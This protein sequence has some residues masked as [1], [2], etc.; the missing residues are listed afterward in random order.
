MESLLNKQKSLQLLFICKK[1]SITELENFIQ[2]IDK[3]YFYCLFLNQLKLRNLEFT[4][5]FNNFGEIKNK[6]PPILITTSPEC[7]DSCNCIKLSCAEIK[8][9]CLVLFWA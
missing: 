1:K 3:H 2:V 5:S 4:G 8:D 7:K 6:F 9:L